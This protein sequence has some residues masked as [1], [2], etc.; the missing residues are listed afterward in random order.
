MT[1]KTTKKRAPKAVTFETQMSQLE[2]L[3]DQ[4]E[5]GGLGLEESIAA[6]EQA[7]ALCAALEKQLTE[8]EKK[9][10]VLQ[11]GQEVPFE[12]EDLA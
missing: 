8:G 11:N 5:R 6:Y 2:T 12:A 9:L 10:S 4:L 3:V 7:M 1:E